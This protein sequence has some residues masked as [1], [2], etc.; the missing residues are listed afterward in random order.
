MVLLSDRMLAIANQMAGDINVPLTVGWGWIARDGSTTEHNTQLL[1]AYAMDVTR[2]VAVAPM[3]LG[4]L[5]LIRRHN[6]Q[7]QVISTPLVAWDDR[8]RGKILPQQKY[9]WGDM[10][11]ESLKVLCGYAGGVGRV[12]HREA[13]LMLATEIS[14]VGEHQDAALA[15]ICSVALIDPGVEV[16]TSSLIGN[17]P[18]TEPCQV[19]D[20]IVRDPSALQNLLALATKGRVWDDMWVVSNDAEAPW[21]KHFAFRLA[22]M[23]S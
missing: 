19:W 11:T 4:E 12:L 20:V 16:R 8:G 3:K 6:P 22:G 15:C 14:G 23:F 17:S 1:N 13:L 10:A 21:P 2:S 9:G 7:L 5:A 18:I